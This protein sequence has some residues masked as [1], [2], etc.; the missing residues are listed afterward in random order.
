MRHGAGKGQTVTRK[1]TLTPAQIEAYHRDGYVL[2]PAHFERNMIDL[3]LDV[4]KADRGIAAAGSMKDKQG[5]GSKIWI[6]GALNPDSMFSAIAVSA[7]IVEPV[8]QLLDDKC[9]H[10]HH[11]M[12]LKEPRVGGA[13]EWHQDYGYWYNDGFLFPNMVSCMVAVNRATRENGCLAVLRG[14]HKAGRIQHGAVGGQAGADAERVKLLEAKL[15]Y[16]LVEL[17]TGDAVF[18]HCNTLHHSNQNLSENPRWAFIGCYTGAANRCVNKRFHGDDLI[19]GG[20]TDAEVTAVGQKHLQT[21]RAAA[22]A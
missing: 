14:S 7:R 11:K 20:L 16:V 22:P 12:M 4:A 2:V 9:V 13:W 18:F 1:Y 6:T 19:A 17:E 21:A 5:L 3:L 8:E 15:Q 10:F